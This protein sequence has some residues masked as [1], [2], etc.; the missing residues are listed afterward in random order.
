MPMTSEEYVKHFG[1]KCPNCEGDFV[2]AVDSPS[3]NEL[4]VYQ[5]CCCPNCGATWTD[6]YKLLGYED[7]VP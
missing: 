2:E 4:N 3:P 7:L 6:V 1:L 5:S